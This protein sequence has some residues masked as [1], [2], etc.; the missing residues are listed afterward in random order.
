VIAA[1]LVLHISP[2]EWILLLMVSVLVIGFELINSALECVVDLIEPENNPLAALAKEMAAGAVLIS[3]ILAVLTG[4][5]I[6]GPKLFIG[7][8]R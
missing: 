8:G 4:V 7:L 6:F 2:L 3:A 5:I 1:A